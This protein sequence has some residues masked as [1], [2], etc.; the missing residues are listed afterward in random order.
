M[1]LCISHMRTPSLS[2]PSSSPSPSPSPHT[3]PLPPA[4]PAKL[5]PVPRDA[6]PRPVRFRPLSTHLAASKVKRD[7]TRPASK[8]AVPVVVFV[9]GR[10]REGVVV[11]RGKEGKEM[12]EEMGNGNGEK[13]GKE[14]GKVKVDLVVERDDPAFVRRLESRDEWL[15]RMAEMNPG[16]ASAVEMGL[17]REGVVG[18]GSM[19]EVRRGFSVR[20]G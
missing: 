17:A 9:A 15:E 4:P 20:K 19:V 7:V 6:A 5:K 13:R 1:G 2:F 11:D 16:Y 18:R 14:N 10:G 8:A 12:K 3:K